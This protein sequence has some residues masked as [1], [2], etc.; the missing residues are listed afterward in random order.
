MR[1]RKGAILAVLAGMPALTMGGPENFIQPPYIY[2]GEGLRDPFVPL[3]TKSVDPEFDVG[4]LI[5]TG[6]LETGGT[7]IA[8]FRRVEGPKAVYRLRY[9]KLLGTDGLP[10]EGISGYFLKDDP[11]ACVLLQGDHEVVYRIPGNWPEEGEE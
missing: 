1:G 7:R 4:D 2:K 11:E 9:E 6:I 8:L 3:K 10:V 5:M